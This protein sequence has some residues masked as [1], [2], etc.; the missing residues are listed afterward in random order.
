MTELTLFADAAAVLVVL[1]AGVPSHG[2]PGCQ[3]D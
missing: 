2:E 1:A 3:I